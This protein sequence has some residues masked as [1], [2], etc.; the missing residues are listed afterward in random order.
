MVIAQEDLKLAVIPL[1]HMW[2]CT[3]DW[4]VM[5]GHDDTAHLVAEQKRHEDEYKDHDVISKVHK[6]NMAGTM[7]AIK[8]YLR[9]HCGVM[10]AHL[11]YII[12]KTIIVQTYGDYPKYATPDNEMITRT[13]HSQTSCTIKKVSVKEHM[14]EYEIDNRSVYDIFD[15]ISNDTDLYPCQTV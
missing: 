14:V 2:I 10:R 13:L 9:S 6:A 1:Y 11:T 15:Q 4:E 5:R 3:F 12:K 7:E 8:E